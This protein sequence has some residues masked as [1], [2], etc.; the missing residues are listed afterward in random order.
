MTR[1]P[2]F[3]TILFILVVP[4]LFS[5]CHSV[6]TS[7]FSSG[8]SSAARLQGI[9]TWNKQPI[10]KAALFLKPL[11]RSGQEIEF[12]TRSDGRFEVDLPPGRYSLR[13]SPSTMCP[14]RGTIDLQQGINQYHLFVN[15]VS[16]LT[17]KPGRI[18]R[19]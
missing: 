18:V 2:F 3:R 16:F 10:R 7:G 14:V 13:S 4:S 11:S 6:E 9:M 12:L 5:A 8:P 17:C 15:P 19:K 1:L